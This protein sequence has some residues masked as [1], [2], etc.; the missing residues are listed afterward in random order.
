[1]VEGNCVNAPV[2]DCTTSGFRTR[3]DGPHTRMLRTILAHTGD[4]SETAT[5]HRL[6]FDAYMALQDAPEVEQG[7]RP[8][9]P[10]DGREG[11]GEP[12]A[13]LPSVVSLAEAKRLHPS[14]RP[15]VEYVDACVYCGERS[16][17]G[18]CS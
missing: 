12:P 1:M 3:I 14:S 2:V 7:L 10:E 8:P 16:K 17:H 13:S 9:A 11:S 15:A 5:L 6:I 18:R 4:D